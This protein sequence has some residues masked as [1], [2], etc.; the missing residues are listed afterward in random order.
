[1]C[2][3]PDDVRE[4][5]EDVCEAV[6]DSYIRGT[7]AD[8]DAYVASAALRVWLDSLPTAAEPLRWWESLPDEE[9]WYWYQGKIPIGNEWYEWYDMVFLRLYDFHDEPS[10][11]KMCLAD[12]EEIEPGEHWG[13]WY[14]PLVPPWEADDAAG[15][16]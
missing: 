13:P 14:G 16:S 7:D 10:V 5:I 15:T 2:S 9:G 1:M 12:G 6:R 3:V 8:V 4:Q 11:M